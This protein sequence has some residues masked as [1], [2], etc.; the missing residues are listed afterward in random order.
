M[1]LIESAVASNRKTNWNREFTGEMDLML[2]SERTSLYSFLTIN[3]HLYCS[4]PLH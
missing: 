2:E 3:C 1:V 4:T